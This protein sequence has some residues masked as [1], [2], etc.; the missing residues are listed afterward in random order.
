MQ[1]EINSKELYTAIFEYNG[2]LFVDNFEA[3]V[4]NLKALLVKWSLLAKKKILASKEDAKVLEEKLK[5]ELYRLRSIKHSTNAWL[6][7]FLLTEDLGSLVIVKTDRKVLGGSSHTR[8][9][10]WEK[11]AFYRI[12]YERLKNISIKTKEI[13]KE[14]KKYERLM[15]YWE[16]K[17][18]MASLHQGDN[19]GLYSIVMEY[20]GDVFV[21]QFYASPGEDINNVLKLWSLE[22]SKHRAFLDYEEDY[23]LLS[24]KVQEKIYELSPVEGL[25]NVWS[26]YFMLRDG[27]GNI[28][29]IKT[30]ETVIIKE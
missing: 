24:K 3:Q 12:A 20:N 26:T 17:K 23:L 29:V 4:D 14:R 10:I 22:L 15:H 25:I 19:K 30:D 5:D 9:H 21:Y 1:K 16:H 11:Y 13:A 8:H 7:F 18:G 2:F 6:T 27:L 28:Y